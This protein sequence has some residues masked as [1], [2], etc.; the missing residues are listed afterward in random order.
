M[1]QLMSII[2]AAGA[3]TRMK[4]KIPKVLHKV[5]GQT[6][7]DHVVDAVEEIGCNHIVAITG[8][9]RE[10]VEEQLQSRGVKFASRPS[11]WARGMLFKWQLTTLVMMK[12]CLYY[13]GTHHYLS[14][15]VLKDSWI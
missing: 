6:L 3:G 10:E 4:S 12:T 11:N 8:H 14:L 7:V 5:S 13:V 15:L 2:L 9:G 1:S